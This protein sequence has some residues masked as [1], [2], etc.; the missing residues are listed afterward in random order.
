[1]QIIQGLA[2]APMLQEISIKNFS[3]QQINNNLDKRGDERYV[4]VLCVCGVFTQVYMK[5]DC[6]CVNGDKR[7]CSNYFDMIKGFPNC[8]RYKRYLNC[9]E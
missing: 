7:K 2:I 3:F 8:F 6:E 9:I 4:H 5:C 1:M